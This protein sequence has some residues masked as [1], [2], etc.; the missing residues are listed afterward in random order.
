[1][2][3]GVGFTVISL[4]VGAFT[5]SC[6]SPFYGTARIEPG[7]HM[8][9]GVAATTFISPANEWFPECIGGR[10]DY[11]IRYGFNQYLQVNGRI[12]A[13]LGYRLPSEG[14]PPPPI[15]DMYP[16]LDGAIGIQGSFP[17]GSVTPSLRVEL[18]YP[19]SQIVAPTLLFGLGRNEW[20]TIGVGGH[21]VDVFV[22]AHPSKRWSF[23]AGANVF[24]IFNADYSDYPLASIGVGYKILN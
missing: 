23:F 1:M 15:K 2:Q 3:K 12:G 21:L 9:A 22:T 7:W 19:H 18:I 20:L 24:S 17:L 16:L 14:F 4:V 8:D 10:G 5:L 6:V 13:G 11:E